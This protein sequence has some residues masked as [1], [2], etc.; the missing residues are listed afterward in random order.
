MLDAFDQ[1]TL[2]YVNAS[3]LVEENT[4]KELSFF[5]FIRGNY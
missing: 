5:D 4:G 1:V 2:A 3:K